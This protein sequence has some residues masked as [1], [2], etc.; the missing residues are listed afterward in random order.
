[1]ASIDISAV[2]SNL[3]ASYIKL[4]LIQKIMFPL[5]IVGSVFAIVAISRWAQKP[6]YAILYS[7]LSPADS[8]AVVE[9]LKA[10]KIKY[11]IRGD[12]SS[13]AISPASMVHEVRLT[14]ASEGIP[15]GGRVGFE[16]FD[17]SNLGTTTFVE[18]LKFQRAL[19]GELERTIAS[20]D[21]VMGARVHIVQ[22]EKT[23]FAKSGSQPSASVLLRLRPGT[24]LSD[25]QVKGIANLVAGSV[26]GLT[27]EQ[28]TIVDIYGNLLT[29][30]P[31]DKEFGVEASRLQYQAQLEQ[32]YV[33]RIEQ[34]LSKVVGPG[35]VI[36]RVTADIDFSQNDREEESYDPGGAVVR[37]ERSVQEGIAE[38]V[39]GGGI[40]GVVSNLNPAPSLL[41]P[42]DSSKESQKRAEQVRNYEVSRAIS[43]SSTPRGK[44]TRLSV[45]VMVDGTYESPVGAPADAPKQ[46]SPL[47][48]DKLAQ[49]EQIVKSAVGFSPDRG[50]TVT[51]ENVPFFTPD[52]SLIAQL[53]ED[54]KNAFIFEVISKGVPVIFIL[55]F[56]LV[57][58][59][60]L[61]KFLVTP[62]EAEVDLS[63][64]LPTGIQELER[65]LAQERSRPDIP[66]FE[67]AVDL[68][69]L[70][71]LMAENSRMVKEN[72]AQA[73]LLIRYWL[74]DGRL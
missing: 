9:K 71:E 43:R 39:R 24:E 50:D 49:I 58:V 41:G 35:K 53:E 61:V 59:R 8:A 66:Q 18:K 62:S 12:G 26:E 55:L 32:S 31:K 68:E 2:F 21:G 45:A 64:L 51:V 14:L 44:L 23:V 22:P 65:E 4:P 28:V 38:S 54:S 7:D 1:M 63:R 42:P 52:Q 48:Q 37:S 74:N 72:P 27:L 40:P 11:E 17:T 13:I 69:Q 73:A 57:I 56:F 25:I 60:P 30:K 15:K 46:F 34:M 33:Q 67:P 70:E 16:L 3:V 47:P 20:I 19:Q 10:N 5:L 29:A 36:A 6:D